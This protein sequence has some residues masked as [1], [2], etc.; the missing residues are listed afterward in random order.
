MVEGYRAKEK[1]KWNHTALICALIARLGGNKKAQPKDFMPRK[2]RKK[3]TSRE[4]LKQVEVWNA[5]L[6]GEDRR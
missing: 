3:K 2:D 5:I 6:G 1:Q 4:I